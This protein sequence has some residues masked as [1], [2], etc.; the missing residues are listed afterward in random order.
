[1][2]WRR[3][4]YVAL[5]ICGILSALLVGRAWGAEEEKAATS[6]TVFELRTYTAH[7]GKLDALNK[8]FREHTT[9]LFEKHGMQNVGY[10][11]PTDG[12]KSKNTLIYIVAHKSRDAAKQSWKKFGEDPVWKTVYA[13]SHKEGPLVKKLESVYMK[14]VDY[15]KIK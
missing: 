3:T 1:M 5:T 12:E 13:E 11:T 6:Q 2:N 14:A 4:S 9:K 15:S 10:W 8:R 7:D